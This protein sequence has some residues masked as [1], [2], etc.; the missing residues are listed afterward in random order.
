[1]MH[2]RTVKIIRLPS[3]FKKRQFSS[4]LNSTLIPPL[5]VGLISSHL[6]AQGIPL[7]QDDLNIRIQYDNQY[8]ESA[9]EIIDTEI[10]FDIP[11]ITHYVNG[12]SDPYLEEILAHAASKAGIRDRHTLL[13]SLPDNIENDSNLTFTAAFSKFVKKELNTINILGGESLWLDLFK[14]KFHFDH[15]DH[16]IYGE[17]ELPLEHLLHA[18]DAGRP[19]ENAEGLSV[20]D[21]GRIIYSQVTAKPIKP[22]FSMLPIEKYRSREEI[23]DYPPALQEI[24]ED[25]QSSR[26]L[27]LPYRFMRGCPFECIFCVSSNQKLE[28]VLAQA[29]AA[30]H[31][32]SLQDEFRPA[33]FLFLH[34][35]INISKG[36]INTL[37]DTLINNHVSILWSD[38]ARVDNLDRDLLFKMRTAGCIRLIFGMETA[39]PRL[40]RYINKG[41]DL[42][43]LERAL[44]W[45]DEAGIWTGIEI[46]CGLPHETEE[47][48]QATVS[49]LNANQ[50][51]INRIYL[52]HFDLRQNTP[53]YNQPEKFGIK[54]VFE[55][56][57]YA[58][59]D[60]ISYVRFGFDEMDGLPWEE[61]A[62]QIES[63]LKTVQERC[64]DGIRYFTD[65]HLLFFLYSKFSRKQDINSIYQRLVKPGA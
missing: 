24:M 51:F 7:Q 28:F 20:S 16:V 27:I 25:F 4:K 30:R 42:K 34:D 52:N 61:K 18:L 5:G 44:R 17:G 65:E 1:M 2:E 54:R 12:H 21:N 39:S 48:V 40:L 57:Q 14:T 11:R 10:F 55:V 63:S 15:V 60:F 22:D 6:R 29:D 9:G 43:Q 26:T 33:G 38:C 46:I 19:L 13:L 56:N 31:L 32:R 47:D 45:A 53:L 41:I 35:T 59:K 37:C 64:S 58:Q 3:F 23:I 36:F 62:R 50:Q 8:P 49:F